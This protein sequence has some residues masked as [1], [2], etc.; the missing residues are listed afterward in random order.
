[1]LSLSVWIE[2]TRAKAEKAV[3][4]AYK[5]I[6]LG[7]LALLLGLS[8]ENTLKCKS[9]SFVWVGG[10]RTETRERDSVWSE[11]MECREGNCATC[12]CCRSGRVGRWRETI[13]EA[14]AMRV[15]N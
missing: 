5:N 14:R 6:M 13:I 4:V 12:S 2:Q 7:K 8:K 11:R 3:S 9:A 15:E 10:K 1:M